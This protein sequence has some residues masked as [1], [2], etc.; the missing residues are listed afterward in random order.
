MW[1]REAEYPDEYTVGQWIWRS[2][3]CSLK[4][5]G[6]FGC[7]SGNWQA[8]PGYVK[9]VGIDT[10]YIAEFFLHLR[11]SKDSAPAVPIEVY[12]DDE[13]SAR[14]TFTPTN[15]GNWNS[16]AWTEAISLGSV[17]GGGHS[18][19]LFTSGQQWGVADL[20]RLY[21]ADH[22]LACGDCTCE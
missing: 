21:L 3:A 12:L 10:P 2:S 7:S 1:S 4:V 15:Q 20:D 16:F 18:L 5:H 11:Y 17:D 8:Q 9:Y 22:P 6:Q 19:R 13:P 14:A